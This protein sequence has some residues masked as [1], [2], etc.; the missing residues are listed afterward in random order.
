M[1]RQIIHPDY[2][3]FQKIMKEIF[4]TQEASDEDE[5]SIEDQEENFSPSE[6]EA[7]LEDSEDQASGKEPKE[8]EKVAEE[9]SELTNPPAPA[10]FEEL[11]VNKWILLQLSGLGISRPSPVQANCI[12]PILAG[13]DCV[14]IAKTGQ[15]KT[16]AFAIPILQTL[17]VDPYGIYAV[18]LTPTREL[19][20]QI[21][22]SFR[23]IGKSGMNL[24]EVVV[25][26]GRDTIKQ[27]LDLEKRPHVII[28]TP[29]R[30]ADHIRTNSTFSLNRVKYLVL[31][32][33]DRLLEGE[34]GNI[35]SILQ[36][37]QWY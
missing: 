30:L 28:A 20:G 26:G 1:S 19:A 15:G 17:A 8:E 6:D 16:L 31:D 12:A 5:S 3:P 29:G 37:M 35:G 21:G 27:S 11:G 4:N 14:G 32:E 9:Q 24:R 13:R 22:D 25:T 36:L 18:I 10:T 2:K 34:F 7:C 33:A 23:S